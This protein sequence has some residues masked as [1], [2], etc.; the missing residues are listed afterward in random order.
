MKVIFLDFDGVINN[1]HSDE[2]LVNPLF[3]RELKK[4]IE[5]TEA[6]VV[7]ISNKRDNFL[8]ENS[9]FLENSFC[10][11]NYIKPLA[12]MGI[13]IYGYIPFI[14]AKQEEAR[15]LEIEAYLASHH[16]IEDFVIIEDDYVMQRL[17]EH[18]VFIEYSDGF[19]SKYV[20][21]SIQ[22]LNG[23]L[24]FYPKE[25]DRSETFQERIK[26]L[27]PSLF[28]NEISEDKTIAKMENILNYLDFSELSLQKNL[29][30]ELAINY[31]DNDEEN[32]YE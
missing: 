8:I 28:L 21:P 12:E 7:V 14:N 10:Y 1:I 16:E 32:N 9:S 18:Q 3:V 6:K 19:V 26:R 27:F 30:K 11:K 20:E 29:A 31:L 5:E 23:N 25:Y 15:E 22:I 24:G 2:V 13:E 17:F 4:V